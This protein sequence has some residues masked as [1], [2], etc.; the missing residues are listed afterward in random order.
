MHDFNK[1]CASLLSIQS[2]MTKICNA[3]FINDEIIKIITQLLLF[4]ILGILV[5]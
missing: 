5:N 3:A 4:K 2:A 1:I